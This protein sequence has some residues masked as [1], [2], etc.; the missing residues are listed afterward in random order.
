MSSIYI[1]E[2]VTMNACTTVVLCSTVAALCLNLGASKVDNS[3][4]HHS[5]YGF[6]TVIVCTIGLHVP[7]GVMSC[8]L[9]TCLW[10]IL[11]LKQSWVWTRI[12]SGH[13]LVRTTSMSCGTRL[14][15]VAVGLSI[16]ALDDEEVKTP[17]S[18]A[19]SHSKECY[20][21]ELPEAICVVS[22]HISSSCADWCDS[23]SGS[24]SEWP[25]WSCQLPAGQW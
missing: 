6:C 21:C 18:M 13:F 17:A 10:S 11:L 4:T 3:H 5:T 15:A 9:I 23:L 7:I 2:L 16:V 8:T 12:V 14:T 1:P 20:C 25:R 19:C 24:C 22:V